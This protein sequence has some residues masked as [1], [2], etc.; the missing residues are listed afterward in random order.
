MVYGK[1]CC[2][3]IISAD[4]EILEGAA[5]S[6]PFESLLVRFR[7][8]EDQGP[9]TGDTYDDVEDLADVIVETQ[10]PGEKILLK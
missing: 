7:Q 8:D 4:R 9:D 6:R 10:Y 2:G 1:R 3:G 5:F